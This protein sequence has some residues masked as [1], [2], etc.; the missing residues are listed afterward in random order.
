MYRVKPSKPVAVF[1]AVFGLAILLVGIFG[2][3][4]TSPGFMVLWAVMLVAI[5]GFNLW[6]AFSKNGSTETIT[7]VDGSA[8]RV[9]GSTVSQV[10]AQR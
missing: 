10:G 8:P 6:T 9:P 3:K 5:V 1:G 4:K 7:T 2:A